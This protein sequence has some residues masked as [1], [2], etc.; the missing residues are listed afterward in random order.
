MEREISLPCLKE[1]STGPYPEPDQSS[2]YHPHPISLWSILI[3]SAYIR[4][5]LH[6]GLF[7]SE[8]PTNMLYAFLFSPIHAACP[9]HLNLLGLIIIIIL[10]VY[11]KINTVRQISK[12]K[13]GELNQILI[14]EISKIKCSAI[15]LNRNFNIIFITSM[16]VTFD[17]KLFFP[18]AFFQ[19]V[20]L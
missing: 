9:A 15:I 1:P 11:G 3:L 5:G 6:S 13:R 2:P 7:P 18:C 16:H 4:L 8:F 17:V 20:N 12:K 10:G 19:S 14:A